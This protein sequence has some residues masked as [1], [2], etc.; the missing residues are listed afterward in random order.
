MPR[1]QRKGCSLS[2]ARSGPFW[3]TKPGTAPEWM[4]QASLSTFISA[5]SILP[6]EA[7]HTNRP[8]TR[9]RGQS[10]KKRW[11]HGEGK[12]TRWYRTN[13]VGNQD[14]AFPCFRKNQP[15]DLHQD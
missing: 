10:L 4:V 11:G 6:G 13:E 12:G 7:R 3:A 9:T 2:L 15:S 1:G 14:V 8:L 5:Q